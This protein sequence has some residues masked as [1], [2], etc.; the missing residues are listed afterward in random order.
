MTQNKKVI[1]LTGGIASGK[2]QVTNYLKDK[3]YL[4]IDADKIAREIV[5]PGQAGYQA[6]VNYFGTGILTEEGEID[7]DRLGQ[8]VFQDSNQMKKLNELL[9]PLIFEKILSLIR[10]A[11]ESI[12]FVDIPLL[13]ETKDE[14]SKIGL[15]FDEVWLVF[16]DSQTQVQRLIQRDQISQEFA[17]QKI[18]SQMPLG[19]KRGLAQ[20]VIDNSKDHNH[21]YRQL[22]R[23]L[24]ELEANEK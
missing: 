18:A 17:K 13:F 3:N 23:A 10:A 14:M 24:V 16:V 9:H 8:I 4:V 7:R 19:A 11:S 20:L 22:D 5:N 2:S 12:V 21:L 15:S 6:V 1:G